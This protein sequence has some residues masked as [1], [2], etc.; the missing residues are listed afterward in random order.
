MCFSIGNISISTLNIT[1]NTYDKERNN[2]KVLA[3]FSLQKMN[4]SNNLYIIYII[5][6]QINY[7]SLIVNDKIIVF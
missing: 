2:V 5:T 6:D 7:F 4:V 1:K 3:E